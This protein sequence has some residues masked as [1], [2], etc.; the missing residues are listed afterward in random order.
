MLQH[1][2]PTGFKIWKKGLEIRNYSG[3]T[4][5]NTYKMVDQF[6]VDHGNCKIDTY[7]PT[8]SK[9]NNQPEFL[10]EYFIDQVKLIRK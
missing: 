2:I 5:Y 4:S 9:L 10:V 3:F 7:V 1:L 8:I 6:I